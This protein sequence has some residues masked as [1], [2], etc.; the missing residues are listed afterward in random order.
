[1]THRLLRPVLLV[2][3]ALAI[4]AYISTAAA[5]PASV[6]VRLT[7]KGG[8][9]RI[10]MSVHEVKA[11]PVEFHVKNISKS[12]MHEFLITPWKKPITAL[13]YNKNKAQVVE[14]KLPHLAG[15]ED[16]KPGAVAIL[17]LP[18]K[19]GRYVVFCD[20][21]GHYSDGMEARFVVKG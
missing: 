20:Q 21:P 8:K 12:E 1:M 11:G 19:P 17:R 13:P 9:D 16:M 4:P 6:K 3:S 18:L 2:L 14:P 7:N 15:V 5:A 10:L